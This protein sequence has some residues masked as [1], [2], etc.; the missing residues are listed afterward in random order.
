MA[1]WSKYSTSQVGKKAA[2]L[3]SRPIEIVS[4]EL[5]TDQIPHEESVAKVT[6]DSLKLLKINALINLMKADG[7]IAQQET[8]YLETLITNAILDADTIARLHEQ[9]AAEGEIPIDYTVFTTSPDDSL[10]LMVDLIAL[11]RRD[12]EL[13]IVEKMYIKHIGRLL[14]YADEDI[15]TMIDG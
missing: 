5:N 7:K 3:L 8:T 12:E 4:D 1:V 6:F 13:H 15:S 14:G 2:D 9:I 10:G 11:A